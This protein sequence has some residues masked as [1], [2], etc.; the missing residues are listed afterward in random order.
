MSILKNMERLDKEHDEYKLEYRA[1]TE[2]IEKY[3]E[4]TVHG[5]HFSANRIEKRINGGEFRPSNIPCSWD[6]GFWEVVLHSC[7]IYRDPMASPA[8]G[9]PLFDPVIVLPL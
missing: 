8:T 9:L 1:D 4:L 2:L 6:C 3:P 7:H 5:L